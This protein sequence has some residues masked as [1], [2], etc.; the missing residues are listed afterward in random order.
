MSQPEGYA[1]AVHLGPPLRAKPELSFRFC[2]GMESFSGIIG[3]RIIRRHAIADGL[4]ESGETVGQ[5]AGG[6]SGNQRGHRR[7]ERG[8]SHQRGFISVVSDRF[9]ARDK[10]RTQLRGNRAQ[11]ERRRHSR[12]I[13]DAAR[14]D[15]RDIA[16]AGQQTRQCEGAKRIIRRGGIEHTAMTTGFDALCHHSVNAGSFNDA[17]FFDGC[18]GCD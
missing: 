1:P 2:R 8:R 6:P 17:G 5:C 9:R 7:V 11:S 12:S 16:C 18:R 4:R 14:R 13:H 10:S 15:H 3:D